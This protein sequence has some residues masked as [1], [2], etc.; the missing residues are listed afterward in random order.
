M[1]RTIL[2][3]FPLLALLLSTASCDD[4]KSYAELLTDENHMVNIFLAQH[5]VE[6]SFP[7][8]DKCEIGENAPYYRVDEEGNV[9]MHVLRIGNDIFDDAENTPGADREIEYPETGDRVYFRYIRYDLT[10]Y[11]VGADDNYGSGNADA[12]GNSSPTFFLYNDYTND[13]SSQYGTGI[14][15]PVSL[16]GY[17]CKVNVLI[18]SQSGPSGDMSYVIPYLYNIS[19]NKPAI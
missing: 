1:K 18:K 8:V 11:V 15:I 9:Y 5:R 13:V 14:Q 6:E 10:Y 16:L 7:G 19:Y 17:N 3:I 2:S 12:P 4:S